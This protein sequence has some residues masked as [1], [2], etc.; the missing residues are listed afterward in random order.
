MHSSEA[1]DGNSGEVDV[2][3]DVPVEL[4]EVEGAVVR[5]EDGTEG[6]HNTGE[7]ERASFFLDAAWEGT[8]GVWGGLDGAWTGTVVEVVTIDCCVQIQE[9][10]S[11]QW[12]LG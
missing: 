3:I 10:D 11:T 7:E 6:P 1:K 2:P 5:L 9:G 12:Y 8:V 4:V